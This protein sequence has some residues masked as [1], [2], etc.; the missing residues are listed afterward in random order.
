MEVL[1]VIII[2]IVVL[3]LPIAGIVSYFKTLRFLKNSLSE[4][5]YD[6]ES[7]SMK[8]SELTNLVRNI[9]QYLRYTPDRADSAPEIVPSSKVEKPAPIIQ[10]IKPVIQPTSDKPAAAHYPAQNIPPQ[11][12]SVM[13]PVAP[14]NRNKIPHETT[15]VIEVSSDFRDVETHTHQKIKAIED[16]NDALAK[17]WSWIIVGEENR[18]PG[19]SMEF[20]VASTWLLRLG[21]I[22]LVVCVAYFLKWSMDR[23]ILGPSGRVVISIITGIGMLTGGLLN[24]N[25]RYHLLAQGFLGGGIAFLYFSMYAAGPM[26][27]L[28]PIPVTFALMILVTLTAGVLSVRITSQL[29]AVLGIIGGYATPIMLS[30]GDANFLVLY[31]YLLVL[32]FGVLSISHV[33]QWRVLNYLAFLFTWILFFAS[34]SFYKP[35]EHFTLAITF[36]SAIYIL[37]SAIVY[38]YNI[39]KKKPSTM[40]EVIHLL[41]NSILF[42]ATSYN[43]I[44]AAHGRPW[45]AV[46]SIA[47]ALFYTAHIYLFL[48]SRLLDRNMLIVLLGLAGFFT[49]WAVPLITEKETLTICWSLMAFFFLWVG[50]K[51]E[52]NMLTG[53]SLL[54]YLIV[55]GRLAI[56]D[57]PRNFETLDWSSK[58]AAEY[59]QHFLTRFW[60]FGIAIG[61]FFAGAWLHQKKTS[62]LNAFSLNQSNSF[63]QPVPPNVFLHGCFWSG[64]LLTFAAVYFELTM[65][66]S[67]AVDIRVPVLTA[68]WVALGFFLAYKSSQRIVSPLLF[69]LSVATLGVLTIKLFFFDFPVWNFDKVNLVYNLHLLQFFMRLVNFAL[70]AYLLLYLLRVAVKNYDNNFVKSFTFLPVLLTFVYATLETNTLFYWQLASFRPGAISVLWALFAISFLALGIKKASKMWRYS[71]LI[72]F[73]VV[74]TK[75]FLLDLSDMEAI[76]RV[77]AFMIVG[78]LLLAGSFVYIKAERTFTAKEISK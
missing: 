61:S 68:L 10:T 32:G 60:T 57:M 18:R 45:P 69:S 74:V 21:I 70:I 30:S 62:V 33:R 58:T 65:V 49:T 47:L 22:A 16:L 37:H 53:M 50:L 35:S 63:P 38:Y 59:L 64:I 55:L 24:L 71:G 75:V 39:A 52:S 34:L 46:L 13:E 27:H 72:L 78:V 7:T 15:P 11:P 43:L 19:V 67:Y 36:L 28:I 76:Y 5:K 26:Y 14:S 77:I 42:T 25:K 73:I 44:V 1:G 54:L 9:E 41:L 48:K 3:A 20:A 31:S 6:I 51:L 40:L 17:M 2:I 4:V 29:I 8:I 66:L 12:E 23:G 56:W